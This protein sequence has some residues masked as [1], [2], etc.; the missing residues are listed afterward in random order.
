MNPGP[1]TACSLGTGSTG[2]HPAGAAPTPRGLLLRRA[3]PEP[4]VAPAAATTSLTYPHW[5]RTP[6]PHPRLTQAR[7]GLPLAIDYGDGEANKQD[8]SGGGSGKEGEED[9]DN[10]EYDEP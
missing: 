6:P 2:G 7:V 3:G 5:T 8:G 10:K 4:S 9:N 1:H